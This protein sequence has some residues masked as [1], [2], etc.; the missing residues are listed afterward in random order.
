MK[1]EGSL[2]LLGVI[3]TDNDGLDLQSVAE[4]TRYDCFEL[5]VGFG[6]NEGFNYC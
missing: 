3:I 2:L 6:L 1:N 4:T 5:M